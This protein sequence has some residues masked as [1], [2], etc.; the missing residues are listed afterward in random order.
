MLACIAGD[1]A[2]AELKNNGGFSSSFKP[3]TKICILRGRPEE[4]TLTLACHPNE[5]TIFRVSALQ[6]RKYSTL[7]QI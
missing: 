4:F 3:M 5:I 1:E 6:H 2:P 7:L